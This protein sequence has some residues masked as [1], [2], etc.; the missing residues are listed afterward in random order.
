MRTYNFKIDNKCSKEEID[1]KFFQDYK[2]VLIQVFCGNN[3]EHFQKT[4][5]YIKKQLPNAI[6]IGSSSD[7]EIYEKE[8]FTKSTIVSISVFE[9]TFI[10]AAISTN[11]NSY[12]KGVEL[13]KKLIVDNTKLLILF[14]NSLNINAED[15][16]NGINSVSKDII[17]CGAMAAD[18]GEYK[19]T[20]VSCEDKIYKSSAVGVSLNSD[21]L[22]VKNDFRFNWSSIGIEHEVTKSTNNKIYEINNLN[23]SDFYRKYL[24]SNIHKTLPESATTFPLLIKDNKKFKARALM[25]INKDGSFQYTGNIKNKDKVKFGFGNAEVI[26]KKPIIKDLKNFTNTESFFIY[27]CLARRRYMP[28][29]ISQES[30]AYANITNTC[31]FFANGEFF[32]E[33]EKAKLLN[34]TFTVISLSENPH[35]N[36]FSINNL[37]DTNKQDDFYTR[38]IKTLTHLIEASSKDHDEQ[39]RKLELEKIN[40]QMLLTSQKIFL[41]HAV[42]ETNTPLSVIMSNIEL[43]EMQYG[44]NNYLSTIEVALKNIFNIYDDL[45]YLVKKDQVLYPRKKIDLVD[46]IRSRIDF[47]YQS[48][49]QIGSEIKFF[50]EKNSL[51]FE[52]NETK[53]QRIID[54]NL[55][56]AIKYT[57][58]NSNIYISLKKE[59]ENYALVISSCSQYIQYPEKIFKEY[60]RETSTKKGFG[61]GLSLVKRICDEE[62]IDIKIDSNEY[63]TSFR[64]LFK[65]REI[66]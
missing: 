24:G 53:L 21:I 33:D 34:Q 13:A 4:L 55:T 17:I 1:F 23:V 51:N 39:S 50:S 10:K 44:K 63:F 14:T 16:L 19:N 48:A 6:C 3:K 2:N 45:S 18:N 66:I 64:Y 29:L 54:N 36:N 43:F 56:N 22:E 47:F 8:V 57:E 58:E 11:K 26:L 35:R 30:K 25:K 40:S 38:N 42:H 61:L 7:G 12:N 27:S 5:N 59:K 46:F 31:G 9:N 37:K 15:F 60:Y 41:R 20:Y 65:E 52:F 32:Y 62:N 49:K 28:H